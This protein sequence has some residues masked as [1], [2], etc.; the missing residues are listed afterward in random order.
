[1]AADG[2]ILDPQ[3]E[4]LTKSKEK[5]ILVLPM[6]ILIRIVEFYIPDQPL[7]TQVYLIHPFHRT[8]QAHSSED[9]S[10]NE[11]GDESLVPHITQKV[12][13][14]WQSPSSHVH[15]PHHAALFIGPYIVKA[16]IEELSKHV[17]HIFHVD[18]AHA[19]S[20]SRLR[21]IAFPNRFPAKALCVSIVLDLRHEHSWSQGGTVVTDE[22]IAPLMD[23]LERF[24]S[25]E[26]IS[27]TWKWR[28]RLKI[29][30]AV[31]QNSGHPV[32]PTIEAYYGLFLAIETLCQV[33]TGFGYE[34]MRSTVEQVEQQVV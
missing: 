19:I 22:E 2:I 16:Y 12:K 34:H 13:L 9:E 24:K 3:W 18:Y 1:M 17:L 15:A 31:L 27:V 25:A 23:F 20:E 4:Q 29:G 21:A 6:E 5:H 8:L 28:L 30:D 10:E 33:G 7:L 26:K 14:L 32:V 11:S